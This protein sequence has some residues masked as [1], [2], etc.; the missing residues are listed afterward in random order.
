MRLSRWEPFGNASNVWQQMQQLQSEMNRL[1]DRWGRG[2]D[3]G[4]TTSTYPAVNVWEDADAVYLEAELPGLDLKD[5][6]IYVTGGT[7]LTIKGL[8]KPQTQEKEKVVYH[9]QERGFGNFVRVLTL[10][11]AVNSEKVDARLENGVLIVKL[12]KHESAKP[13]KIAVKAE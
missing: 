3:E 5:L 1:F 7:Q 8:R 12:A 6:E 2:S 13:R 4:W 11:F 9:R 10:P